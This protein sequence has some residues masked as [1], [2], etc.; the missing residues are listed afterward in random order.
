MESQQ[1]CLL[2]EEIVESPV[3]DEGS[4]SVVAQFALTFTV[5][6]SEFSAASCWYSFH[7]AARHML[8]KAQTA[9]SRCIDIISPVK[10]T[11]VK[12]AL[13]AS[14][15]Q[16]DI[17]YQ[18]IFRK[19]YGDC[20]ILLHQNHSIGKLRLNG[21]GTQGTSNSSFVYM[22]APLFGHIVHQSASF[23]NSIL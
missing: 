9:W 1:F 19:C 3:Y 7:T 12:R 6:G 23:C 17:P 18:T 11:M 21:W 5:R 16:I 15:M 10:L 4:A 2:R 22:G 8:A 14:F 13:M 20:L